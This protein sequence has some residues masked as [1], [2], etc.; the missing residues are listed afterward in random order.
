MN[1]AK[2]LN[3]YMPVLRLTIIFEIDVTP[4]TGGIFRT[5][6]DINQDFYMN[7]IFFQ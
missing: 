4:F 1:M 3:I 6:Q 7:L 2:S 5:P